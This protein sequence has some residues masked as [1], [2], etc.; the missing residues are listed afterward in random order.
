[1]ADSDNNDLQRISGLW[2]RTAKNGTAYMSGATD[3]AVPEGS[4]LL[5]FR[6]TR[7]VEGDDGQPDYTLHAAPA[8]AE[9]RETVSAGRANEGTHKGSPRRRRGLPDRDTI[10]SFYV[11]PGTETP[12]LTD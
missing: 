12:N 8:D 10:S 7:K 11:P 3:V 6:N 4:K 1:M 2:L 5:V 9:K